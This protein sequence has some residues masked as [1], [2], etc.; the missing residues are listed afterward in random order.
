MP[1]ME[2]CRNCHNS[3]CINSLEMSFFHTVKLN[4]VNNVKGVS[5]PEN[6]LKKP[7]TA[8]LGAPE[9]SDSFYRLPIL[10]NSQHFTLPSS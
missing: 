5:T 6:K 10:H 4:T 9:V 3:V 1:L 2:M 7:Q 8:L